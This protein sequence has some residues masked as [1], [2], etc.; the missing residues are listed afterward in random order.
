MSGDAPKPD[1]LGATTP[2]TPD[3]AWTLGQK[4]RLAFAVLI[5]L[6]VLIFLGS[7]WNA[8]QVRFFGFT[9]SLPM[10][11]W[12]CGAV[13]GGFVMGWTVRALRA[14]KSK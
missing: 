14:R 9:P 4:V 6:L 12:L 5:S 10:A 13:G 1:P 2:A 8:V 11:V 7:N 3:G